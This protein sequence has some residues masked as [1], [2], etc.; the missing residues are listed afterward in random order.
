[1][2]G[3]YRK[4]TGYRR[5]NGFRARLSRVEIETIGKKATRGCR[6]EGRGS[7]EEKPKAA[8][9]PKAAAA[10]SRRPRTKP[11]ARKPTTTKKAE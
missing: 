5:Q 4:R 11:A 10:T 2:I 6:S 9:K 7:A 3:K 8:P 1:M